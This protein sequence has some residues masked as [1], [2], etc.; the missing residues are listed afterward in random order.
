MDVTPNIGKGVLSFILCTDSTVLPSLHPF[1]ISSPSQ[2]LPPTGELPPPSQF[3]CYLTLVFCS[4]TVFQNYLA[5]VSTVIWDGD[6]DRGR[7]YI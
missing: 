3:P 4:L 5:L 7:V 1:P 6:G 2:G